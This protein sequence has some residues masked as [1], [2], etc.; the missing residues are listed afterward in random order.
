MMK[1]IAI[2]IML[3]ATALSGWC[4]Q[5]QRQ[6]R[7]GV[8][9]SAEWVVDRYLQLM[10]LDALRSDSILYM[11]TVIYYASSPQDT[12]IMKR[13]FLPPN[14][15]R[16][17]LWH[18]DTL[19]EGTYTDGKRVFREYN[20]KTLDGWTRVAESR[21]YNVAPTYEFR[22]PLYNWRAQGGV[23]EYQGVWNFQ[24]NEVYRVYMEAP[25][26]YNSYFFFEKN[27]GLLFLEQQT[28]HHSEYSNHQ[29]SVHPDVHG[30][31]EYQP[32]GVS[33][34][35]SYESF[36][37]EGDRLLYLTTFRYLPLNMD[38]FTKDAQ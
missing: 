18:G 8:K 17:E 20:V 31:H 12:A 15:F 14:R 1:R 10:N 11:E 5:A 32:L 29:A 23:L 19:L 34:L 36:Q 27:S 7:G 30:V 2:G 28:S 13:W 3:V 25:E 16:A 35:P 9:D 38:I 6:Q 22:G 21:Y 24:G 4:Q 37:I 33:L 26:R